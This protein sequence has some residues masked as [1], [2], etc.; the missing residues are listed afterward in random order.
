M[1]TAKPISTISFNS[2]AHLVRTLSDLQKAK[3]IEFWAY[4]K[5]QPEDDEAGKK[6]HIHLY[7]EPARRIQTVDLQ[8]EFNEFDPNNPKPRKC[9]NFRISQFGDWYLYALHDATY[10]A[11]KGQS[12]RFHYKPEDVIPSDDDELRERIATIDLSGITPIGRLKEF[13]R[14]GLSFQDAVAQGIVPI[15]QINSYA[16]AWGC[17]DTATTFR[18]GRPNHEIDPETG[19]VFEPVEPE[20]APF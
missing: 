3:K 9:L 2:E 20:D 4:I 19:E 1:N 15:P 6:E 16:V 7:I 5:H 11:S 17:L 13:K 10:L 14:S 18:N 8:A 12:R